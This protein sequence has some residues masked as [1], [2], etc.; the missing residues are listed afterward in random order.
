MGDDQIKFLN[1]GNTSSTDSVIDMHFMR[2]DTLLERFG[3]NST[4]VKTMGKAIDY[5]LCV[6]QAP[7]ADVWA[8]E[9]HFD[10]FHLSWGEPKCTC[11]RVC[12]NGGTLN[13]LRALASAA[14]MS[15]TT[16]WARPAKRPTGCAN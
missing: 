12:E 7:G 8:W 9:R 1:S 14:E 11:K 10:L 3:M 5:H 4:I 16:G 6:K 2:L 13:D 15:T